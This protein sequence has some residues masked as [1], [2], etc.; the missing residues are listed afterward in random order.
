[1][2]HSQDFTVYDDQIGEQYNYPSQYFDRVQEGSHFIYC[3]PQ[4]EGR[5]TVYFGTGVI[6]AISPDDSNNRRYCQVEEFFEFPREVRYRDS[7]RRYLETGTEQI[8]VMQSAVRIIGEEAFNRIIDRS[9]LE[10][11][12]FFQRLRSSRTDSE[13]IRLLNESYA[14]ATPRLKRYVSNRV[15]RG[16]TI[17]GKVKE[18]NRHICQICGIVP[19]MMRTKRP[20]AEAHHVIPLHKLQNGSL[21]SENVICVCPN[22]HR[23]IHYGNVTLVEATTETIVFEIEGRRIC[24]RRNKLTL[25]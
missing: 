1:M 19:F 20:Y 13:R 10:Q 18:L 5:P 6:G 25:T 14:S 8:P 17:G 3:R 12:E 24:I 7:G 16:I 21:T 4:E 9:G 2:Q 11:D 22:C 23:K 15:E